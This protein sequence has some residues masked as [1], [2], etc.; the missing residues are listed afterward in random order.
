MPL[1]RPSQEYSLKWKAE[2]C[3]FFPLITSFQ[4]KE[5]CEQLFKYDNAFFSEPKKYVFSIHW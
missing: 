2:K 4:N 5:L 1:F 3:L